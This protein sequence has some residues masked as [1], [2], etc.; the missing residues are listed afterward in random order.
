MGDFNADEESAGIRRLTRQGGFVDV[1]RAAN[2][3]AAGPTVW[4]AVRAPFATVRRR[5]DFVFL[6]PGRAIPGSV[7]ASRVVLDVP[8]TLADGTVLWPSDHYGVLAELEL[9]GHG[10]APP[11]GDRA[12]SAP[13]AEQRPEK[14]A[15]R[16]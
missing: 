10:A 3:A 16:E 6:V 14:A 4:Q 12:P 5:V 7:R 2:P 11:A 15:G 13:R 8:R 1:F 9:F